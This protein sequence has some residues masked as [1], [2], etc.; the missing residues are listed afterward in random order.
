MRFT[1]DSPLGKFEEQVVD[2]GIAK[3]VLGGWF[4]RCNLKGISLKSRRVMLEVGL[5]CLAS[6]AVFIFSY[7]GSDFQ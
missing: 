3:F 5:A 6:N 7:Q 2:V 4:L 1:F